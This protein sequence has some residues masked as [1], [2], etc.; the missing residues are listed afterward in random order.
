MSE[1]HKHLGIPQSRHARKTQK[2][3]LLRNG[4]VEHGL[5]ACDAAGRCIMRACLQA[6]LCNS[7]RL[8]PL[9]SP[10]LL[11]LFAC[12]LPCLRAGLC[13]IRQ[14]VLQAIQTKCWFAAVFT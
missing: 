14:R 5:Y 6:V 11:S 9:L 3:R 8:G 12:L 13:C 7:H 1:A 4:Y 10:R 2:R